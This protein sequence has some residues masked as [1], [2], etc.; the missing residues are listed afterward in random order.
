MGGLKGKV[1]IEWL[2]I[3]NLALVEKADIEFCSGFN[4]I[5]GETG[6]G[7]SVIMSAISLLLGGRAA[8]NIVRSGCDKCEIS[9]GIVLKEEIYTL[10][11]GILD[12][13]GIS[14]DSGEELLLKRTIT[15]TRSRNFI[16]DTPVALQTLKQLGDLLVDIHGPNEHQSLFKASIQL[17]IL[18]KFANLADLRKSTEECWCNLQAAKLKLEELDKDIP[19]V[20]EAEHLK[21]I[22]DTIESAELEENEDVIVNEKH[23]IAANARD[24]VTTSQNA[25]AILNESENSVSDKLSELHRTLLEIDKL[26]IKEVEEFI[27]RCDLLIENCRE[28]SIDIESFS[29]KI[30]LDE[31]D[32]DALE[33]RLATIQNLKRKFGPA[34]SDIAKTA[35]EAKEKL[36]KVDH[37]DEL[38]SSLQADIVL[39]EGQLLKIA[40]QLSVKRKESAS[41]FSKLVEKSMKKLGFLKA[42]FSVDFSEVMPTM[43]GMDSIEFIFSPN[44]GEPANP[45]RKVGSSGEISRIMLALKTVLADADLIPILIFDE[46]DVNIGGKTAVTVGEELSALSKSHQLFS[47]SHLPQVAAAADSHYKVD[48]EISKGRT[49]TTITLLSTGERKSELARMLGDGEAAHNHAKDLLGNS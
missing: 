3:K 11:A 40:S 45:L 17:D 5:T 27:S 48:K 46:I 36:D 21:V 35:A 22:L 7:K 13:S 30:D 29:S 24:I 23:K 43:S 49:R 42:G 6:S 4:V 12:N 32:F 37:F 26:D 18:D 25:M 2:S 47:I 19:S 34:L 31:T 14:Y 20:I 28:L 41:K 16:N 1:M 44:P 15:Q 8:K 38:R 10:I 9:A 39:A 33:T